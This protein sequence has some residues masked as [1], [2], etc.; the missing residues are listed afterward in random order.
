MEEFYGIIASALRE[1]TE[2]W[3]LKVG[4]IEERFIN[5]SRRELVVKDLIVD[6][7]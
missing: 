1:Q 5:Y 3:R 4:L 2:Q 6:R 7:Y